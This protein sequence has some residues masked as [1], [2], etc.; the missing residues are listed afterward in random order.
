MWGGNFPDDEQYAEKWRRFD[1]FC[2]GQLSTEETAW[3]AGGC[4]ASLY[5][6]G[7]HDDST[8]AKL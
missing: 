1:R 8:D 6:F 7:R 2:E 4:V 5:P 3:L